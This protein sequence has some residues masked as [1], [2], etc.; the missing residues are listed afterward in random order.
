M[1][2]LCI[3]GNGFDIAHGIPTMYSDFRLFIID[4][5]PEALELRDEVVTLEDFTSIDPVEF[6]AEIL[7]SAMDNVSGT[8]WSNF[9]EALAYINFDKKIPKPNHKENK[10]EQ[11][12]HRQMSQYLL[13][14][15]KITNGFIKCSR[16]WDDFFRS[17]ISSVQKSIDNKEYSCKT[18]LNEL[19]K[20]PDMQFLSFNYTKTLQTLY[21]IRKVIH[22]HNRVGQKLIWGHGIDKVEYCSLSHDY[23]LGSSFLN[24]MLGTFRKDTNTAIRKYRDFFRKLDCNVDRVY[25]Y[26]FSYGAVDSI[27]IKLIIQK[28]SPNAVWHFTSYE[29]KDSKALCIKKTKLRRYGFKGSFSVFE[30]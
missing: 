13:Y 14:I 30:G 27:Y 10:T 12:D 28:I 5:Y 11:D 22:I 8:N 4:N 17:W 16:I 29:A 21:D 7:L 23:A 1:G 3:I 19:L 24:E 20:E 6:A 15:D 18:A 9:E 26:G 2:S 25:S